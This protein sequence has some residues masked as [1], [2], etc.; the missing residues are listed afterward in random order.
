MREKT[1]KGWA[2]WYQIIN[3][4]GG[5]ELNHKEIVAFLKSKYRLSLW[6]QQM[7]TVA[8]EQQVSKREKHQRNDSYQISKSWTYDQPL[9]VLHETWMSPNL[10]QE[11]LAH[12]SLIVGKL[13]KQKFLR[14]KWIDSKTIVDVRFYAKG[15]KKTQLIIQHSKINDLK[16]TE[17]LKNYWQKQLNNLAVVLSR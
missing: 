1:G 17:L 11:W 6:W 7:V 15:K 13:N 12:A 3:D 2:E 4:A 8:Y 9:P 14:L 10:R 5:L 16:Q